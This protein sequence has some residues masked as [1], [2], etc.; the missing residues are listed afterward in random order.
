DGARFSPRAT[1]GGREARHHAGMR[2]GVVVLVMLT[3]ATVNVACGGSGSSDLFA[4][5]ETPAAPP[6]AGG[7]P[8]PGEPGW[9][10]GGAADATVGPAARDAAGALDGHAGGPDAQA[11]ADAGGH[12][13][14]GTADAGQA[15]AGPGDAGQGDSGAAD[16]ATTTDA[17]ADAAEPE[18]A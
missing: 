9:P 2:S 17:G 15:D 5:G 16:S 11:A 18:E 8:E 14:A 3:N 6:G 7:G 1:R 4:N 10:G 13:D 12:Q